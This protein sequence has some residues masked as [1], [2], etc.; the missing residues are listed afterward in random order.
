MRLASAALAWGLLAGAG[1]AQELPLRTWSVREG[2]S[3]S[4]V[5]D[6]LVDADGFVWFAT[7]DGLCRFD[8][9]RFLAYGAAQGL[10]N[11]LVWCLAEDARGALWLGT[12]GGGA[13]RVAAT[14]RALEVVV[15][16]GATAAE[17]R[18]FALAFDELGRAWSAG[19]AGIARA[20]AAGEDDLEPWLA[21]VSGVPW[22]DSDG[23]LWFATAEGLLLAHDGAP[24]LARWSEEP[25]EV[26]V[27]ELR[28]AVA[29][30]AG[31]AWLACARAVFHVE[32]PAPDD[33]HARRAPLPLDL[34]PG[35]VV[36]DVCVD[37]RGRPWIAATRGLARWEGG[38]A[39]W[40][41]LAHGLPD[42][43]IRSLAPDPRGG[44][45]VG[46]HQNGV[47]WIADS[48]VE[49]YGV[50]SGLG[51]GHAVKLV[52]GADGT[53]WVSTEISGLYE[54]RDG[55]VRLLPGSERPPFDRTQHHLL[56]AGADTWWLGT[57]QGLFR[58]RGSRLELS[59]AQAVAGPP[60]LAG[61]NVT[62]LGLDPDGR[63]TVGTVRGEIFA[64]S[65]QDEALERQSL[66][67]RGR[68]V[69]GMAWT[70][71][72]AVWISDGLDLWRAREGG[73]DVEPVAVDAIAPA[74]LQP[75][76]LLVDRR[77]WLW[78]GTRFRGVAYS[79]EPAAPSPVFER[80]TS[81]DGLASDVVYALTE[82]AEGSLWIGTG[83]GIQRFDPRTGTLESPGVEGLPSEW[84]L[85][86]SFDERGDLWCASGSGVVRMPAAAARKP[87]P[88]SAVRFTRCIA[89]GQ[90]LAL[91]ARGTSVLPA[92]R[93]GAG[94]SDL[95][96][97][98]VSVDPMRGAELAYQTRLEGVDPD[99][100]APTRDLSVRFGSL[101]AGRHRLL[102]RCLALGAVAGAAAILPLEV[103]PPV[104]QRP[105]AIVSAL[106][107]C[108]A[109]G[110]LA[111]RVRARRAQAF[112][113]LRLG[114]AADLHDDLGAGLAAIAVTSEV[115][116]GA[117]PVEART[118]MAEVAQLARD[119]RGSMGDLVWAVDPRHDSLADVVDRMRQHCAELVSAPG[120]TLE[121]HAPERAALERLSVPPD[122]RRQLVLFLKEAVANVVR[123][124][125]AANVRIVL[126]LEGERLR[127]WVADDGRGFDPSSV[128]E[129]RG[130]GHLRRRARELGGDVALRSSPGAGTRVDLDVPLSTGGSAR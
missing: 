7:W 39:R 114:I 38:R 127:L 92:L 103:T 20:R 99:W 37:G 90:E 96:V 25:S 64:G 44:I 88:P 66:G 94:R 22:R 15:D 129:G 125:R 59:A 55:G 11:A 77:G 98:Y 51:D 19:E 65:A 78:A 29:D 18:V 21:G 117:D 28:A 95:W 115:A 43:W 2:L 112:D 31:G 71:D 56:R 101:P 32:R 30:G 35:D 122:R 79:R 63:T 113:R 24:R 102:V 107:L 85:D 120:Q 100:S 40:F 116:R 47:A 23:R 50:R 130:L 33:E 52:D 62:W 104:W 109:A 123:H 14:G 49:S 8:G 128:V 73:T 36:F 108:A 46:T 91:P 69:R 5:N 60:G 6:I 86:L 93:L 1:A 126:S 75:R 80:L 74:E 10:P 81:A 97:E 89:G 83:R 118:R 3:Q 16:P 27:G 84:V 67:L 87:A 82:D 42:A 9:R 68:A 105:W 57:P 121:F 119:L 13:A 76:E 106:V 72:G 110:G 111:Q 53:W 12:H 45:W 17:R 58:A 41:G 61:A 26:D 54:L 48:G 124:A 70:A 34:E 4:R